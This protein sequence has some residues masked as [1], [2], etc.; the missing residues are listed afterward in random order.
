[1]IAWLD[2]TGATLLYYATLMAPVLIAT[3]ATDRIA[4]LAGWMDEETR[5]GCLFMGLVFA[6]ITI[7]FGLMFWPTLTSI[8]RHACKHAADFASCMGTG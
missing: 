7:L 2:S 8:A 4:R 5:R 3:F 6:A 1:M